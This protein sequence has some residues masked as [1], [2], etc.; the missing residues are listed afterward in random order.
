MADPDWD[1]I[2]AG[3]LGGDSGGGAGR[4]ATYS[5]RQDPNTGQWYR[6]NNLSGS[7]EP[8]PGGPSGSPQ[9]QVAQDWTWI[10]I[11]GPRGRVYRNSTG[12]YLYM[13]MLYGSL[14]EVNSIINAQGGLVDDNTGEFLD[15]PGAGTGNRRTQ[16]LTVG[17]SQW[18]YDLDTGEPIREIGSSKPRDEN[19][20]LGV[21]P[22][23]YMGGH[24]SGSVGGGGGSAYLGGSSGGGGPIDTGPSGAQVAQWDFQSREGQKQRDW[25]S[26]ENELDRALRA[27][28]DAA[29]LGLDMARFNM[30]V[31]NARQNA[32]EAYARLVS[33]PDLNALP[34]FLE[35]GGGNLHNAMAT[36]NTMLTDDAVRAGANALEN[37]RFLG[38]L[39][40]GGVNPYTTQGGFGGAPP[41]GGATPPEGTPPPGETPPGTPPGAPPGGTGFSF[42]PAGKPGG[43]PYAQWD[44]AS[45]D[46]NKLLAGTDPNVRREGWQLGMTDPALS[47][48]SKNPDLDEF[49]NNLGVLGGYHANPQ[50]TWIDP[51]R[52][53]QMNPAWMYIQP[54]IT[55]SGEPTTALQPYGNIQGAQNPRGTWNTSTTAPVNPADYQQLTGQPFPHVQVNDW[56]VPAYADGGKLRGLGVVGE[57]GPE[58]VIGDATVIPFDRI[59]GFADGGST[60]NPYAPVTPRAFSYMDNSAPRLLTPAGKP[61]EGAMQPL[62]ITPISGGTSIPAPAPVPWQAYPDGTAGHGPTP[63][64]PGGESGA[65]VSPPI[66]PDP[67]AGPVQPETPRGDTRPVTAPA[68]TNPYTYNPGSEP[69]G[70]YPSSPVVSPPSGAPPPSGQGAPMQPLPITPISG[71]NVPI[72]TGGD[73]MD[74]VRRFR[75]GAKTIPNFNPYDVGFF[76]QDPLWQMQGFNALQTKYGIPVES[77]IAEAE[78]MRLRGQPRS[79]FAYAY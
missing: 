77:Q 1:A 27:Q 11:D 42:N 3:A 37:L 2:L 40:A 66:P 12:Q 73:P 9:Q 60:Q 34:A 14:S 10:G 8:I 61:P 35:A 33:T 58:L 71:G 63:P 32:A 28:Q 78:R 5:P 59:A 21:T 23:T 69:A 22:A 57:E 24:S 68:G 56:T 79:R 62:P 20:D 36:G 46:W 70:T 49:I 45:M 17:G 76:N 18:L 29:R 4:T 51:E 48:V 65:S 16:V 43:T 53:V 41:P 64:P 19:P 52:G 13:D 67:L 39:G 26:A 6:W 55:P 38:S 50:F 30:D 72:D 74:I 31:F 47:W 25:Q 75:E 44:T 7:W 15:K 54:R